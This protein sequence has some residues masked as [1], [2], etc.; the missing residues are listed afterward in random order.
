MKREILK[1]KYYLLTSNVWK[2]ATI[3]RMKIARSRFKRNSNKT[4]KNE[5]KFVSI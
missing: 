5:I 1:E 2:Y 3:R 4:N